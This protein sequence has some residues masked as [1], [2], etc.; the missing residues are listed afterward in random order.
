MSKQYT[1]SELRRL[2]FAASIL[3]PDTPRRWEIIAS[4][5]NAK[6]NITASEAMTQFE[7]FNVL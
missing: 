1:F 2:A 4:F 3:P 5:V 7:K 6:E